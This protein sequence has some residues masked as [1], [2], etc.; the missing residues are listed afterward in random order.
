MHSRLLA[1]VA[2]VTVVAGPLAHAPGFRQ[3]FGQ[4][5]LAGPHGVALAPD[6]DVWVA[7]TGHD[8]VA[9]FTPSGHLMVGRRRGS[10]RD[11]SGRDQGPGG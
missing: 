10:G 1:V 11:R 2:V 5:V 3:S 8:R 4:R 9:E 7:D 6:G